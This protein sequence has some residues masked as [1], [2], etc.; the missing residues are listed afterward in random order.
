MPITGHSRS[1]SQRPVSCGAPFNLFARLPPSVAGL[2]PRPSA[3][4]RRSSAAS[5]ASVGASSSSRW[6]SAP[7]GSG[8]SGIGSALP[9]APSCALAPDAVQTIATSNVAAHVRGGGIVR[10]AMPMIP[11]LSGF[12]RLRVP[13]WLP[14]NGARRR[15]QC[16]CDALLITSEK[17]SLVTARGSETVCAKR[18]ARRESTALARTLQSTR[19]VSPNRQRHS[20]LPVASSISESSVT[21]TR[22][23]PSYGVD[24]PGCERTR[25]VPSPLSRYAQKDTGQTLHVRLSLFRPP[26]A[27]STLVASGIRT[28]HGGHDG[29]RAIRSLRDTLAL[30]IDTR[31][32]RRT[33]TKPAEPVLPRHRAHQSL[34]LVRQP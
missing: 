16:R 17:C 5:S 9:G 28:G 8:E 12:F 23:L 20:T 26:D 7:P 22:P 4:T 31:R 6:E 27:E 25:K 14:R 11:G 21:S 10:F 33:V 15:P 24:E 1:G 34:T 3:S 29:G 19:N 30:Q 2:C 13:T 18:R 32:A